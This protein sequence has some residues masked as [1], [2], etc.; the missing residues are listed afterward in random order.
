[1]VAG[2]ALRFSRSMLDSA[3]WLIPTSRAKS[4]WCQPSFSRRL[5]MAA[6]FWRSF[7]RACLPGLV[8]AVM[9]VCV[10]LMR[11]KIRSRGLRGKP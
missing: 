2:L 4:G 1:M 7:P 3:D 5:R 10:A 11:T 6:P 9:T 8:A